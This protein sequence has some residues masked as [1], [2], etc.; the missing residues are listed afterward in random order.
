[1]KP[2]K[3][4]KKKNSHGPTGRFPDGKIRKDDNGEIEI[5]IGT[6]AKKEIVILDFG[7][8]VSWLGFKPE[9]AVGL[10]SGIIQK[11]RELLDKN[12]QKE[13]T[14]EESS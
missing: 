8:Q 4:R 5:R 7:A 3:K 14:K 11:A 12:K 10:A 6:D 9:Q 2:A 1:M 13:D